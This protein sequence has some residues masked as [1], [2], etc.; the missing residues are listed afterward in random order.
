MGIHS[1]FD[2]KTVFITGAANGIGRATALAFA[3]AGA[4]V[5]LADIDTA[6]SELVA[7]WIWEAGAKALCLDCNVTVESEIKAALDKTVH[8][9]GGLDI[10]FNNAGESPTFMPAAEI[11]EKDWRHILD[12]NV[13]GTH[14]CM[15]NEI[16]IMLARGG[17]IIV[18][19]SSGCGVVGL[20]GAAAYSASKHAVLGLTRTAALDYAAEG[21]RINAVCPGIIDTRM[22]DSLT[23]D[24]DEGRA[25][26]A[27]REP[28]G[29]LGQPEEIA[30]A[31]LWLSSRDAG[32]MIGHALVIDGGLTCS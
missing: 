16:P 30:S 15:R 24:T 26:L 21:I 14:L 4:N 28:I 5:A 11:S 12:V 1:E 32:F 9:F 3:K 13:L 19:T 7:S 25:E 31:V 8:T 22:L 2:G 17:G 29:R 20:K 27:E 10:A 23:G 18:N 6:A